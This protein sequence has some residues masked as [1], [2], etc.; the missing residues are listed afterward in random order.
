[1]VCR[2]G[3]L[4]RRRFCPRPF[5]VGLVVAICLFYQSLTLRGTRKLAATVPGAAPNTPTETQASR[6]KRRLSVDE[7]CFFLP[8]N[9]PEIRKM[10]ESMETHFGSHG[11]RAIV[12]RPPSYSTMELRVHQH[13]LAQLGYTVAITEE[14]SGPDLGPELLGKGDLGSWDLLICLSSRKAAGNPC[15]SKEDMCQLSLHQKVNILPEIQHQLCRKE[16]LCQIIQR[17]PELQ[18]PVSPSVCLDQSTQFKL[19]SWSHLLKT[20][21][22]PMWKPWAWRREQLDQ[23]TVLA[24]HETIFRAEDLS[25]ILKAYVLVTSLTPLRA[26]IHSTGMVWNPPKRKRFTVKL[27]TFFE[28]FL[29]ASSPLQALDNMK[30]AI[31]KLL[32]ATEAFSQNSPLGPKAFHR[33]SLCFQLL[34]FDIGY[35][36]FTSPMVL[37][38][39][40]HL[41]F[42]DDDNINFEDQ[43]TE[44]FLLK[45][46]FNFLFSN[47]S[48]LSIFSEIFQRLYRSAVSKGEN[49]KKELNRCLSLEEINSIMTFIKELGSLGQFQLLFPSTSPG[50]QSWMREFYDTANPMG[51]ARSVLT[52]HS[53]LLNVFEQFQLL[54]KKAQLHPLE[55]HSFSEDENIEKPQ[56]P[57]DATEHKKV[58]VQQIMNATIEVHC[59][60][61][62]DIQCHIKQI[63]TQ[64]HLELSPEFSPKIKDYYSEVP[65]DV[66]TVTI[67][68][69][70]SNCQCKVYLHERAGPS[71]ANYP[72]GLGTNR[73][74]MLVV[75]ESLAQGETLITYKLTIYREDRPSLPLFEDFMACGF[76][77]DCGLLIHPEEACGLQPISSD[78]IEAISQPELKTCPSGDT[79]GQW[80]MPCLS[81]SDNRTCDWREITWQPHNCQYGVLSKPQLQQCLG[82]RKAI[83]FT[84][85]KSYLKIIWLFRNGFAARTQVS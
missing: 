85:A 42:Q 10:E 25:V 32:L 71:I 1:M 66:V 14:R 27:Q 49:Y 63:F 53:S 81:C 36:S 70:T 11:R 9:A 84:G 30:E 2:P 26:F 73:I 69:E 12:Y 29:R 35:G 40:G 23:T 65:F 61:D 48:S 80:I 55:W 3:F 31:S 52:Q 21:K 20:A 68:V 19:S 83:I 43:N 38:V 54:N 62:E 74:S 57:F 4:C 77:Q 22:L 33:C 79:K 47:E 82:A 76:V 58:V 78:Y 16:G 51:K 17:F 50:I 75:D 56:V 44:E 59:S 34:T 28:T 8:G 24:P 39:H 45:D 18:L 15:I 13:I 6:C 64:P 46:T 37:Q 5:L 72:L 7:R 67:G 41:N 60:N